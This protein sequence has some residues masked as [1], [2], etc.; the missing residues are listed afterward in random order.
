MGRVTQL[1]QHWVE[2]VTS[3][4]GQ[5]LA[6]AALSGEELQRRYSAGDRHYHDV[7]H[8]CVVIN[9][10]D[11]L[12]ALLGCDTMSRARLTAAAAAH[13]VIYT[14]V[15]GADERASAD[16]A[17]AALLAAGVAGEHAAAVS[18]LVLLTADHQAGHR[19][20][21]ILVDADLSILGGSPAQ[22]QRYREDVRA[23]Y[24]DVGADDWRRGRTGVLRM[25]LARDHLY[26]TAPGRDRW[27]RQARLN[28]TAEL[29]VLDVLDA[30]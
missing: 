28:L 21:R 23:D 24:A 9:V 10:C 11:E 30:R 7:R 1:P 29:D 3:L 27:E 5:D 22:Y 13:D 14:G 20:G 25:L 15:A 19:E 8:A 4:G 17:A 26:L 6:Q 18:E 16:W 2:A 12:A